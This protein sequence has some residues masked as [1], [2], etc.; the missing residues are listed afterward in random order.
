[1]GRLG[2]RYGS[3]NTTSKEFLFVYLF[4]LLLQLRRLGQ[5]ALQGQTFEGFL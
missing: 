4:I 2:A 5:F 1:M 3:F